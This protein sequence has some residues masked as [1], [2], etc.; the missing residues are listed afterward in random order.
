MM[1][2]QLLIFKMRMKIPDISISCYK[3]CYSTHKDLHMVPHS[4][5]PQ[6]MGASSTFVLLLLCPLSPLWSGP[7]ARFLDHS[8]G[9]PTFSCSGHRLSCTVFFLG[10]EHSPFCLTLLSLFLLCS[11]TL[12]WY[13]NWT[14]HHFLNMPDALLLLNFAHTMFSAQMPL[15][16]WQ[17]IIFI[18]S[19]N[20][21]SNST[22]SIKSKSEM[23][24]YCLP[25]LD[26]P[27]HSILPSDCL[28][29]SWCIICCSCGCAGHP[30][31]IPLLN[32]KWM[33]L[34]PKHFLITWISDS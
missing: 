4:A 22:S 16:H 7:T 23:I 28:S 13:P 3:H 9:L 27:Q 30:S 8:Y 18:N 21:T 24:L 25:S 14:A 5:R 1:W 6:D 19:L 33:D 20:A 31:R 11:S 17:L 12:T 32:F 2:V 34:H 10:T 15:N 26:F 29:F